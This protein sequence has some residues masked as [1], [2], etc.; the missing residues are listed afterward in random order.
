MAEVVFSNLDIRR[1]LT[2]VKL[3]V[4]FGV[5]SVPHV[6]IVIQTTG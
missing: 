6:V 2:L 3:Q 5:C 1:W 4:K